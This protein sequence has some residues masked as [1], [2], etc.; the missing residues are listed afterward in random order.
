MLDEVKETI[1]RYSKKMLRC[2][3]TRGTGGNIS[4]RDRDSGLIAITGSGIDYEEMTI[5]DIVVVN[6]DGEIIEGKE[7][8]SSE[9]PMH[10]A[11]YKKRKD[12]MAAVHTHSTYVTTMACMRREIEP[13]H[14]LLGFAGGKIGCI[15]FYPIGSKQLAE[16]TAEALGEKNAVL[17][18]NHGLMAVGPTINFAFS[19]AEESEFVA[20]L[21]FNAEII[22]KAKMLAQEDIEPIIQSAKA[23]LK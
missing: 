4:I 3:L 2:G 18:G 10:L 1:L 19:V 15:P 21:F 6:I 12:V 22:G 20:E 9:L 13:I 16:N 8:P 23:Y 17:L 5:E 11:C 7:K 14:Y